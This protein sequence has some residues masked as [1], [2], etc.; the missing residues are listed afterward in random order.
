[1]AIEMLLI[2][3]ILNPVASI[4]IP[5]Q[6]VKSPM[7]VGFVSGIITTAMQYSISNIKN[8][9][10]QRNATNIPS[11]ALNIIEVNKSKNALVI[12]MV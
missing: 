9:G 1:M 12:S 5:P 3:L 4:K 11:E 7:I 10:M 2:S 8:W 6:A